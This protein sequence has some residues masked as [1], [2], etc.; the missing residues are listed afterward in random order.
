MILPMLPSRHDEDSFPDG[1]DDGHA[2]D[3]VGYV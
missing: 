2:G 1:N 3:E